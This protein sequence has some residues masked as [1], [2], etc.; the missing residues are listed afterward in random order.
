MAKPRSTII[1]DSGSSNGYLG[2]QRTDNTMTA[3]RKSRPSEEF[4]RALSHP[5][6]RMKLTTTPF[7]TL[8][9]RPGISVRSGVFDQLV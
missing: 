4:R 1:L 5:F 7:A 8:P 9:V 3:S 2:Y 6:H